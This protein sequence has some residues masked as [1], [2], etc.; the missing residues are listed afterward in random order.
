MMNIGWSLLIAIAMIGCSENSMVDS[1]DLSSDEAEFSSALSKKG[2]GGK[3]DDGGGNVDPDPMYVQ[4]LPGSF[5]SDD[6]R[7]L[8]DSDGAGSIGSGWAVAINYD[9]VNG[10]NQV[11]FQKRATAQS[12]S[13]INSEYSFD[14]LEVNSTGGQPSSIKLWGGDQNGDGL[15]SD[16]IDVGPF[17]IDPVLGGTMDLNMEINMKP[18]KGKGVTVCTVAIG[19]VVY[20]PVS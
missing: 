7:L 3:P 5:A 2:G 9:P 16:W 17:D 10:W 8:V 13:D 11:G 4:L 12:C 15:K 6:P 18:R 1:N 14:L 20:T 19:S